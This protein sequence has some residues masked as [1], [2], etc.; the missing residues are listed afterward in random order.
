MP[1]LAGA[2]AALLALLLVQTAAPAHAASPDASQEAPAWYE[3]GVD[4]L[5]ADLYREPPGALVETREPIEHGDVWAWTGD[6][7]KALG[8]LADS[9]ERG[10]P[11]A[12]S[13]V[14]FLERMTLGPIVFQ[15]WVN[16]GDPVVVAENE[17]TLAVSNHLLTLEADRDAG[18]VTATVEYHDGRDR[19]MLRFGPPD[20]RVE[21]TWM[22]TEPHLEASGLEG[23]EDGNLTVWFRYTTPEATAFAN[24][25]IAPTPGVQR[26]LTLAGADGVG[27]VRL[28]APDLTITRPQL[29]RG[30][31]LYTHAYHPGT[32]S[33]P[34]AQNRS[35]LD[36]SQVHDEAWTL[37][38]DPE[39]HAEFAPALG[40]RFQ[41]PQAFRGARV[42][43]LEAFGTNDTP[44]LGI[45]T[46]HHT[47]ELTPSNAERVS[48]TWAP[49]D[50]YLSTH[51]SVYG[52]LLE[53]VSDQRYAGVDPSLTYEL[54]D[55]A[56][57][58]VTYA[59]A[60]DDPALVSLV[61]DL[62][63]PY[64]ARVGGGTEARSLA[65]TAITTAR[66]AEFTG[67][68]TWL[69]ETGRLAGILHRYQVT[70]PDHPS[71]GAVRANPT[72]FVTIDS[73]AIPGM[74]WMT[75]AD[76]L[77]N[78]TYASWADQA[79]RSL[80]VRSGDIIL[81]GQEGTAIDTDHWVYKAGLL[82]RSASQLP[83]EV[84][85]TAREAIW[86]ALRDPSTV[87]VRTSRY[88]E[89]TNSETQSWVLQGLLA[90]HRSREG[91]WILDSETDLRPRGGPPGATR[92]APNATGAY[93]WA[94][95]DHAPYVDGHPP[96]REPG[97]HGTIRW[98]AT[99]PLTF[100]PAHERA[101]EA[102]WNTLGFPGL[103]NAT[104]PSRLLGNL[105]VEIA[106]AYDPGRGGWTPWVPDRDLETGL[107]EITARTG[108]LVRLHSP[109]TLQVAAPPAPLPE[110]QPGWNLLPV[111]PAEPGSTQPRPGW[112]NAT[113]RP[114]PMLAQPPSA[115]GTAS[116]LS[117]WFVARDA[118]GDPPGE[119]PA[120]VAG[121]V[122]ET[123][124]GVRGGTLAVL[125]GNETVASAPVGPGGAVRATVDGLDAGTPLTLV[126]RD[127]GG[128]SRAEATHVY[129]PADLVPADLEVRTPEHPS[130]PRWVKGVFLAGF[131][132]SAA[133]LLGR[134]P[135]P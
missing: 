33:N 86:E 113:I 63:G 130:T 68:T 104:D 32:G 44:R 62:L 78:A 134:G 20:L 106:W 17:T 85:W 42:S 27:A 60:T 37:Y 9:A 29:G 53:N 102:G 50:G 3:A 48:E 82:L 92:L 100:W 65:S 56:R 22:D 74:A 129:R 51:P 5:L 47:Y 112:R 8:A 61:G 116:P 80:E 35:P 109:A 127:P 125:A 123:R 73:T 76:A 83:T 121:T 71:T 57:G 6:N 89:E 101:L 79:W 41:D 14:D 133:V 64:L 34:V 43:A 24:Y 88:S 11:R 19:R 15:R 75:A 10:E 40:V 111:P 70:D 115:D 18:T 30:T 23:P 55:T 54:G 93:V 69:E 25:T 110:V 96:P 39:P 87:E 66:L 4:T 28:V 49:L 95:P 117:T 105:P 81:R 135:L 91:P 114:P 126:Y 58:L 2:P 36:A 77:D 21:G 38:H 31:R 122:R 72:A 90:D 108:L 84:R 97:P 1:R 124:E 7:G 12:R 99:G 13:M 120:L 103:A 98:T 118:A 132:A 45:G 94:T 46:L 52:R 67:D 119:P 107:D 59:E 16:T 128:T 131:L 26:T